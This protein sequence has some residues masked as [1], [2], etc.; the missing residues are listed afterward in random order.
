MGQDV[1]ERDA[2]ATAPLVRNAGLLDITDVSLRY[3]DE[4]TPLDA[5]GTW[6]A[7]VD[8]SWTTAGRGGGTA[9]TEVAARLRAADGEVR[10][11]GFVDPAEGGRL[12]LWLSGPVRVVRSGDVRV[13]AGRGTDPAGYAAMATAARPQV[14]RVLPAW[15][16]EL[17]VEV[18]ADEAGLAAAL[19]VDA[20]DYEDV[21][22]VTATVDG[23]DRGAPV[24]VFVNP[25]VF[26][27][28]GPR[29]AQVVMTHEATHVATRAAVD[30]P[31]SGDL[32]VWLL[33]GF[34][35]YVALL[36]GSVPVERAAAQ[37]IADVRESGAPDHLPGTAEFRTTGEHFGASYEAAW[38]ACRVVA[39]AAGTDGLVQVY[40]EVDSGDRL[41]AALRR[42]AGFGVAGLTQ[43]WRAELLAPGGRRVTRARSTPAA[44]ATL[45]VGLVVAG[46]LAVLL[47]PWQPLPGGAPP[48]PAPGTG[49]PRASWTAPRRTRGGPAPGAGAPS[50]PPWRCCRGWPCPGAGGGWPVACAVRAGSASSR[51]R[52]RCS[53]GCA[54]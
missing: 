37:V 42:H 26:E 13:V 6:T 11:L 7:L 5:D 23:R 28:L 19:G 16:G 44:V 29:G 20:A 14:R 33:E 31:A 43:R 52:R 1:G 18:P 53:S 21:A 39:A 30:R 8:A 4:A 36:D 40:R 38:L 50:P 45:V 46:L 2:G 22:A 15:R 48:L 3:V 12:P 35:D 47:V 24:H 34:A 51:P 49:S 41:D 10:V 9:R 27:G 17:V 32:P 25:E 54:C